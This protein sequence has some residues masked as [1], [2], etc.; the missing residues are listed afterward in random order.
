[1]QG[2]ALGIPSLRGI[3]DEKFYADLQGGLLES[4]GRLFKGSTKL[5]VYPFRDASTGKFSDTPHG[6]SGIWIREAADGKIIT[7]DNLQVAPHLRHLY[8]HL[9]ENG[10][11]VSIENYNPDYLSLFP[12]LVL[13]KIQ[14]GDAT[15]ENDV[16]PQIVELIKRGKMFGWQEKAAAVTA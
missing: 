11:I 14:S 15:W 9:L 3:F 2:I 10:H 1:M 8:A 7:A 12:P 13:S 6:E 5:Y 16:P 4:L